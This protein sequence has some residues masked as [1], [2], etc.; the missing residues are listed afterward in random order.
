MNLLWYSPTLFR[1]LQSV[2]TLVFWSMISRAGAF[3]LHVFVAFP[4][5]SKF[6]FKDVCRLD[7]IHV[8]HKGSFLQFQFFQKADDNKKVVYT[9]SNTWFLR[10]N[11]VTSNG[12]NNPRLLWSSN[13]L[14]TSVG[15]KTLCTRQL[16]MT[17]VYG[18]TSFQSLYSR[19]VMS[20]STFPKDHHHYLLM[21]RSGGREREAENI[22]LGH[23]V[24]PLLWAHPPL[25]PHIPCQIVKFSWHLILGS[26]KGP[27][28]LDRLKTK[29]SILLSKQILMTYSYPR[30]WC[31]LYLLFLMLH[32]QT[33][34]VIHLLYLLC[35]LGISS[36]HL[37]CC[38]P[39]QS[40]HRPYLLLDL[41]G[42][43]F[44][45]LQSNAVLIMSPACLKLFNGFPHPEDGG[46]IPSKAYK[47]LHGR[48]SPTPLSYFA[49]SL[50]QT[51]L[52]ELS[53]GPLTCLSLH[54]LVP[55]TCLYPPVIAPQ[56]SSAQMSPPQHP[57][58]ISF[59]I[60]NYSSISYYLFNYVV[61]ICLYI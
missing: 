2:G 18:A 29:F 44:A 17:W 11:L 26:L 37:H 57:T 50:F 58:L 21:K 46:S 32:I 16:V 20:I 51:L 28:T 42:K 10:T 14:E 34:A 5:P 19:W 61:N 9:W 4:L 43:G 41:P 30:E 13:E 48:V 15:C 39:G 59:L 24:N 25:H 12:G 40:Y 6:V 45:L 52:C 47:G 55:R 49:P 8:S 3:F 7:W 54:V 60:L 33:T 53:I 1:V 31:P 27:Q 35:D 56:H 38:D 22:N 36:L 23:T